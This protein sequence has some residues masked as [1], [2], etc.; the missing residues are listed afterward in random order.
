MTDGFTRWKP[1]ELGKGLEE[2]RGDDGE[3]N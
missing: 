1:Y 2:D 3:T